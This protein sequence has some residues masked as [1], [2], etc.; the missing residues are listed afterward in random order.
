M[1]LAARMT[2]V[3]Y[4]LLTIPYGVAGDL[5]AGKAR[6]VACSG[7]HGADGVAITQ[8]FPNLA[9]QNEAYLVGAIQAYRDGQRHDPT[10]KAM[11]ASLSNDDVLNLAAYFSSLPWK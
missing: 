4:G 9:G 6:A 7:C 5:A 1:Y 3:L 10:M 8:N 2:A 11:V